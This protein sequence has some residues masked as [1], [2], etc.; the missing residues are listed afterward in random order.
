MYICA[1]FQASGIHDAF[2]RGSFVKQNKFEF[3]KGRFHCQRVTEF[4]SAV[5]EKQG[6]SIANKPTFDL[7]TLLFRDCR[8]KCRRT[9]TKV[10]P[11]NIFNVNAAV[12][13]IL[14]PLL[15]YHGMKFCARVENFSPV[16]S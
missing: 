10:I 16:Y 4:I 14:N 13:N 15:T 5:S 12:V 6:D 7:V 2:E 1:L 11:E 3:L 8:L 9:L